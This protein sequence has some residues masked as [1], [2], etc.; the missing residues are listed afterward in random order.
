ME[1]NVN[2]HYTATL[3]NV[4]CQSKYKRNKQVINAFAIERLPALAYGLFKQVVNGTQNILANLLWDRGITLLISKC[5]VDRNI[6]YE[7]NHEDWLGGIKR[8]FKRVAK[9]LNYLHIQFCLCND[10]INMVFFFMK[11]WKNNSPLDRPTTCYR[12]QEFGG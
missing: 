9:I 6:I 8:M 10:H 1:K 2:F 12:S 4:K 3:S 5:C 7:D 11:T